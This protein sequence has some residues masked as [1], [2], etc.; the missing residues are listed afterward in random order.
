MPPPPPNPTTRRMERRLQNNMYIAK[1]RTNHY[2]FKIITSRTKSVASTKIWP[3][4]GKVGWKR[5]TLIGC[6]WVIICSMSALTQWLPTFCF[7]FKY[8]VIMVC[9][10]AK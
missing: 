1:P 8:N 2:C 9:H 5:F 10:S 3:R 7:H 4:A 6:L